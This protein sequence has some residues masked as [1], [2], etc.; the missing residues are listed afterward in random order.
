MALKR[1]RYALRAVLRRNRYCAAFAEP[2][3]VVV[4]GSLAEAPARR[5]RPRQTSKRRRSPRSVQAA[6]LV[7][8][9]KRDPAIVA[10]ADPTLFNRVMDTAW[11][12]VIASN[13]MVL[14]YNPETCAGTRH[15]REPGVPL[16]VTA[17]RSAVL[18]RR[19]TRLAIGR[20][21]CWRSRR[22]TT[23]NPAYR[24]D[25]SPDQTY[26]ETQ[27]LA[28]FDAGASTRRSSTGAWPSSATTRTSNSRRQS[29]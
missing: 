2:Y 26:P 3:T 15:G 29:T 14:A 18:T 28:Q 25:L 21:S 13:E 7:A 4:A 10:L 16:D 27:L 24:C 9:G 22:T 1:F 11:H 20:G 19:S 6:R 17:S 5:S 8:D 23:T 12:A